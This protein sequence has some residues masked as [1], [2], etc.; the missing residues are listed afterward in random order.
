M[1]VKSKPDSKVDL[2]PADSRVIWVQKIR[3]KQKP[4]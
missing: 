1:V 3:R 4:N 2:G